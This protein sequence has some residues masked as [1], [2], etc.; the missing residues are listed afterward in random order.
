M[1]TWFKCRNS[2][3]FNTFV[4]LANIVLADCQSNNGW[5]TTAPGEEAELACTGDFIG[6]R[7]RKCSGDGVWQTESTE[8]CLPKYPSKG[9][10]YVDFV[11]YIP[12]SNI[13][14]IQK[15]QGE[16]IKQGFLSVYTNLGENEVSVY[17]IVRVDSVHI[18]IFCYL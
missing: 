4:V 8:Y 6:K 15:D 1:W 5:P 3:S 7:T 14:Q 10:A 16:G 2:S 11:L 17:R 9:S 18:N 13:G 12:K